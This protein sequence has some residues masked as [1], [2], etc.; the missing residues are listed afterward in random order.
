MAEPTPAPSPDLLPPSPF[1]LVSGV[2]LDLSGVIAT[3]HSI[4]VVYSFVAFGFS[5]LFIFGIVYSKQRYAQV[6]ADQEAALRA[7]E[8][9]WARRKQGSAK[10]DRWEEVLRHV[11]SPNP[12]DWRLAIIE[13]DII[14]EEVLNER[15]LAGT[16]IGDKLKSASP[17]QF[18]TLDD[19][20]KAHRVRNEIAHAGSDF[21]L[22][23]KLA[24]DTIQRFKNVFTELG[25]I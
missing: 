13:A 19:A 10:N 8:A 22:T 6:V 2:G 21:V 4:W 25:K 7:A 24:Q 20:W 14:L 5:L 16:T 15:G 3:L 9:E 23:Q 11:A 12:N 18:Q 17:A 1:S